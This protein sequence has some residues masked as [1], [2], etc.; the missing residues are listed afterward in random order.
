MP[1][2]ARVLPE[3]RLAVARLHGTIGA[4]DITGAL[5]AYLG[6]PAWSPSFAV[7]W[8]LRRIDHVDLGP[9]D[10]GETV[11]F[12]RGHDEQLGTGRRAYVVAGEL[13][14]EIALL[15]NRM[16]GRHRHVEMRVFP[17]GHAAATWLGVPAEVLEPDGPAG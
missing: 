3:H 14:G 4:R 2:A 10:L 1:Y 13:E 15:L 11:A 6:D 5:S 7:A 12:L 16:A 9:A 17:A 8:D